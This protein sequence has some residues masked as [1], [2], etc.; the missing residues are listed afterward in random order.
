MHAQH[1]LMKTDTAADFIKLYGM[2]K[3]CYAVPGFVFIDK[4]HIKANANTK[5]DYKEAQKVFSDGRVLST[6]YKRPQ[7]IKVRHVQLKYANYEHC[8]YILQPDSDFIIDAYLKRTG[9]NI[10]VGTGTSEEILI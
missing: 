6:S 4:N 10:P 9:H 8:P 7:T 1:L 3:A 5:K 2:A